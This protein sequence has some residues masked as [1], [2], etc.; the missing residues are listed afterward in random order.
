[1][2]LRPLPDTVEHLLQRL[3]APPRLVAHLTL[4]HDMAGR[5]L[6]GLL[7]RWPVLQIDHEAVLF[8]AAMHDIGKLHHPT[9]LSAPG[10]LHEDAGEKLLISLGIPPEAARF[11]RTHGRWNETSPMED[12]L[13]ALADKIW[14]GKRDERLED[15][16][17]G[18]ISTDAQ[19][20]RWSVYMGLDEILTEI[21]NGADARL[22]WHNRHGV[23]G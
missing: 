14:K 7:E 13:V 1:M 23:E 11:C 19:E 17:T 3:N 9:E 21:A 16:V 5:L 8:G 20:E 4:T 15:A 6:A 2:S 12:L 10:K 18:R 22:A